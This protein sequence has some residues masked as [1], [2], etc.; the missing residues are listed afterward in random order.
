MSKPVKA[1]L[2][3]LLLLLLAEAGLR[4]AERWV[5]V[6]SGIADGGSCHRPL[7]LFLGS[8]RTLRGVDPFLVEQELAARG[9]DRPWSASLNMPTATNVGLYMHYMQ[10]IHPWAGRAEGSSHRWT[11]ADMSR[12][13]LAIE[14]RGSGMNDNYNPNRELA[15]LSQQGDDGPAIPEHNDAGGLPEWLSGLDPEASARS[16]LWRFRLS[17]IR[18]TVVALDRGAGRGAVNPD[19]LTDEGRELIAD[20]LPP[21]F[22]GINWA[23]GARGW[24]PF[25]ERVSDLDVDRWSEHYR[26]RLLADYHLGGRQSR[27][28]RLIIRQAR[29][30]GFTPL[31]YL[32]PVTP[33]HRTFYFGDG[34]QEFLTHIRLLAR[35]EGVQLI[36]LDS[37]HTLDLHAYRDTNH[38]HRDGARV[39]SRQLGRQIEKTC[40]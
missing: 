13:I 33:L 2:Y 17:T 21:Q 5:A 8:S 39:V 24:Q 19:D 34:Y 12:G 37:D 23:R 32:L 35:E 6:L 28:L 20:G 15:W 11:S 36:D 7:C 9:W 30:D 31:L 26:M 10:E 1:V 40:P 18:E 3:S 14:V 4:L 27:Y 16:L 25:D 29:E 22:A 38:L